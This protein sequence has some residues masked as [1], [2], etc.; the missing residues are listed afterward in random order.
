MERKIKKMVM[1]S[2]AID[3]AGVH[4]VRVLGHDTTQEY[5]P[6]LMLDSFDSENPAD[7]VKGFP[8]HPHRGIETVTYLIEGQIDHEDSLGNQGSIL[9]GQSQWMTAASGIMHQEMPQP[10]PKMLGLQLW[11]NMPAAEKMA[12]PRYLTIT[13]E[14]IGVKE[15]EAATIRVVAG[16][17][18]G[19]KGVQ[20]HHIQAS[21]F[22]VDLQA[23]KT[24]SMPT[25]TEE[26]V[27]V[28]LIKGDGVID[29]QHIAEK[30]A[31][32]FTEGDSITVQ[33]PQ[34]ENCRFIFCSAKPL[35]EPIA[36]GGPIVMNTRQELQRAFED[37]NNGTFIKSS[38]AGI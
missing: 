16:E 27:F 31:V 5:D 26:T 19:A 8:T 18:D 9:S 38:A 24:I 32:L 34:N 3:G 2:R 28:F 1:G 23:G 6:F 12:E 29:G 21:F 14:M 36:W 37:L 22:D 17:Y 10:S 13:Q 7:Y 20:P 35:G 30:T 15:T 25:K 33:A 11:L 4:L